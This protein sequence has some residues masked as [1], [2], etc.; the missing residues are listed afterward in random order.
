MLAA[1]VAVAGLAAAAVLVVPLVTPSGSPLAAPNAAAAELHAIAASTRATAVTTGSTATYRDRGIGLA[2]TPTGDAFS[3]QDSVVTHAVTPTEDAWT[4]ESGAPRYLTP[5]VERKVAGMPA[6]DRPSAATTTQRLAASRIAWPT[7]EQVAVLPTSAA[8]L[9]AVLPAGMC[10]GP[11][12]RVDQ[13]VTI[14]EV[15]GTTAA[16][17]AAALDL[18]AVTPG[19]TIVGPKV[20]DSH[21]GLAIHVGGDAPKATVDSTYLLDSADGTLLAAYDYA[22]AAYLASIPFPV[23]P[24]SLI[25]QRERAG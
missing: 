2:S 5:G 7:R 10:S 16:Q 13:L 4:F 17:R 23:A 19:V 18:M 11:Y 6:A 24:G 25:W 12:C 21:A 8:A 3:W 14:I 1:T 9:A 20:G 15:P 22:T